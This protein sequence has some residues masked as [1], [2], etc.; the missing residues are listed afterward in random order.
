[1]SG[2]SFHIVVF[3][4]L[5]PPDPFPRTWSASYLRGS[6]IAHIAIIF[7]VRIVGASIINHFLVNV[8]DLSF[9][10]QSRK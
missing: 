2:R 10:T 8:A 3:R 1:M 7:V 9:L 4:V 5:R 6:G